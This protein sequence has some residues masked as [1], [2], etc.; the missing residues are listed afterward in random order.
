MD[1]EAILNSLT[2]SIDVHCN[3]K[4]LWLTTETIIEQRSKSGCRVPGTKSEMPLLHDTKFW[5][6]LIV[7][8][9][10]RLAFDRFCIGLHAI[11]LYPWCLVLAFCYISYLPKPY[12]DSMG[13]SAY[14][15]LSFYSW[16]VLSFT[17]EE[18]YL[19]NQSPRS[20]PPVLWCLD[21]TSCSQYSPIFVNCLVWQMPAPTRW[22][23]C[24]SAGVQDLSIQNNS[25]YYVF[26][27]FS[28]VPTVAAVYEVLCKKCGERKE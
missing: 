13:V 25:S 7:F 23:H 19:W 24:S 28:V 4:K 5:S 10:F 20:H 12:Q 27:F 11:C 16:R 14:S 18:Q 8:S 9:W 26:V 3:Y 21:P 2:I 6:N 22:C 15:W 1:Y 17:D